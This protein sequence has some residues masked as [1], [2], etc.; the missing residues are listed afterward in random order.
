MVEE[1]FM[2]VDVDELALL[3]DMH[4]PSDTA[5]MKAALIYVEQLQLAR[6]TARLNAEQGVA[7]STESVLQRFEERRC[8]I[9]LGVRPP[10]VGTG[11]ETKARMWASAWRRRWGGKHGRIRVRENVPA[12]ELHSK[13]CLKVPTECGRKVEQWNRKAFLF[14]ERNPFP[15]LE[16]SFGIPGWN[17]GPYP[18]CLAQRSQN[19]NGFRSRNRNGFRSRNGNAFSLSLSVFLRGGRCLAVV[20][21]CLQSDPRWQRGAEDQCG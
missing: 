10:C 7:P 14:W 21:L 2:Q 1:H 4:A 19:G 6:W 20:E 12:A 15:N 18:R 9:P 13:A 3:T 8:Q 5:A 16:Q 17:V 11:A